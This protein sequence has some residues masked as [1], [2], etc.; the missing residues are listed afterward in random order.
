MIYLIIHEVNKNKTDEERCM[1]DEEQMK[2]LKNYKKARKNNMER[3][4]IDR[5]WC[6]IYVLLA[7]H[8]IDNSSN[9]ERTIKDLLEEIEVMFDIYKDDL[10]LKEI[11]KNLT[12]ILGKRKILII[13]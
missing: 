1:E 3:I 5:D 9:T 13:K 10:E 6:V 12:E 7:L 2:Y 8:S 11:K 4:F